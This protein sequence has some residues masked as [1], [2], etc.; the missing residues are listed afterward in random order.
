MTGFFA[1]QT[2]TNI[3][4]LNKEFADAVAMLANVNRDTDKI[5]MY[6]IKN[7]MN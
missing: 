4:V 1:V 2:E 3:T 6:N 7:K 5:N